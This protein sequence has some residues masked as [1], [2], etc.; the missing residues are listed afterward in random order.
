[1][2]RLIT[3]T[4]AAT[5]VLLLLS[6]NHGRT[7]ARHDTA[8][9]LNP[10]PMTEPADVARTHLTALLTADPSTAQANSTPLLARQLASQPPRPGSLDEVPV[11]DLLTL[12]RTDTS[13][14][15]AVQMRWP[16]GRIA[17]V[18]VQLAVVDGRWLVAGVQ[19]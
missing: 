7:P 16:D 3:I 13:T 8:T 5:V 6:L 9:R 2:K 10:T 1:M 11:F 4:V 14:D 18:R 19:P 17:A 15:L 12:D